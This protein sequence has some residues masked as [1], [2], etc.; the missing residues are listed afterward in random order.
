MLVLPAI[1]AVSLG[2]AP[3][4]SFDV[5][6]WRSEK[7]ASLGATLT[8][9]APLDEVVTIGSPTTPWCQQVKLVVTGEDGKPLTETWLWQ[10]I[11]RP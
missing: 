4:L 10:Y 2:A 7:S 8:F 9:S 1:A 5:T 6:E 11:P 3:V